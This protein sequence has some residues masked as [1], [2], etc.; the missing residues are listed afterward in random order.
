MNKETEVILDYGRITTLTLKGANDL[1]ILNYKTMK[2]L[3]SLISD[4]DKDENVEA[5]I[6]T[7]S[8]SKAFC[9]GADIKE[10][11]SMDEDLI[12]EYVDA[13]MNTFNKIENFHSPVIG[14]INGYAFGAAFELL[15][16]CDI[17]V[18]SSSAVIGQP[19]VRHGLIPPF[20]GLHRL[21]EI[22]GMGIA[23]HIIFSSEHLSPDECMRI[24]LVNKV[25]DLEGLMPETIKLAEQITL[26]KKYS[27]SVSKKILNSANLSNTEN[28][29][30]N[31][32]IECLEN[33]QTKEQLVSFFERNKLK[34]K[35]VT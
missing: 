3:D 10:L 22:V 11:S 6:I 28:S 35:K 20:G 2:S 5:L 18:M 30:K 15:L 33:N 29:E 14:C 34:H 9:S 32:L 19:A 25:F 8:G 4:L 16:T 24:G 27:L 26:G 21:P 23:K 7:G 31:A 17:R 13:G 1:N 12:K